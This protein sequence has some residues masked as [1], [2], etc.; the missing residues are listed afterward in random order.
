[1]SFFGQPIQFLVILSLVF[2]PY[3]GMARSVQNSKG[4][5]A[6]H[7]SKRVPIQVINPAISQQGVDELFQSILKF[8]NI[9]K[10]EKKEEKKPE[11][12]KKTTKPSNPFAEVVNKI[13]SAA[14]ADN[15]SGD[16][17][18]DANGGG[19][20]SIKFDEN[21]KKAP[22]DQASDRN[23][24]NRGNGLQNGGGGGGDNSPWGEGKVWPKFWAACILFDQS[25][26][27]KEANELVKG[28]ADR[29][30]RCKLNFAPFPFTIKSEYP[31]SA[32]TINSNAKK[33]CNIPEVFGYAKASVQTAVHWK[34]TAGEMCKKWKNGKPEEGGDPSVAGCAETGAGGGGQT[35]SELESSEHSG[36]AAGD[37]A[38]SILVPNGRNAST[39]A[40]EMYGHNAMGVMN[41]GK[42]GNKLGIL[43]EGDVA[44]NGDYLNE[45]GCA[46]FRGQAI[47]NVDKYAFY[48][49]RKNYYKME[50][51]P[52]Y[53]KD[54][55]SGQS[56]FGGGG[57]DPPGGGG[58][59][60]GEIPRIADNARE[61]KPEPDSAHKDRPISNS[62]P[63][64]IKTPEVTSVESKAN[65][66]EFFADSEGAKEDDLNL[67]GEFFDSADLENNQSGE[68][69]V[70]GFDEDAEAG[71]KS[72]GTE[73]E[74][75]NEYASGIS[76]GDSKARSVDGSGSMT[77]SA[78][79]EGLDELLVSG[80]VENLEGES[81]L[82][83]IN[84]DEDEMDPEFWKRRKK[85][86]RSPASRTNGYVNPS[87]TSKFRVKTD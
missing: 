60:P 67:D 36:G 11:S 9:S 61:T 65:D 3:V 18:F 56:F 17:E 24:G 78:E 46:I 54:L 81:Y 16:G 79:E 27:D 26:T 66:S 71:D 50:R 80:N 49:K 77:S 44:D 8:G 69:S 74:F 12:K 20:Q 29:A 43:G 5:N 39:A 32:G 85:S 34:E 59:P 23:L 51:N 38:A 2:M 45:P 68:G 82:G 70:L 64:T 14:N 21:A 86:K 13:N 19:D 30:N 57:G 7:P 6:L 83:K 42:Y 75:K 1:M 35:S 31:N 62:T 87:G 28:M 58:K 4:V 22:G 33:V 53:Q 73:T 72:D 37:V 48:P 76:G 63:V 84:G 25:T 15:S 41:G 52:R 10:K 55:L 40:H 47:R